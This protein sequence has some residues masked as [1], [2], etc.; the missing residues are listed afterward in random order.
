MKT[1]DI[2]P[3]TV[4]AELERLEGR[5]SPFSALYAHWERNQWSALELDLAPDRASFVALEPSEQSGLIWI[6]AHRFHAE[7][8]VARLLAPFLLAAPDYEVQLLLATQVADEHRHLQ[9]VLRIYEEVFGIQGGFEA[10][11]AVA[12]E[13]MDLVAGTLYDRLEHYVGRL[14]ADSGEEEFL[15]AVVVYHLLAEGVVARTAQNLAANR[16]EQLTFPGLAEGQRLVARDEARH[17]GIGVSYARRCMDERPE[18]ARAVIEDVVEDFV[19]IAERLLATA[20]EGMS[21]LV[22]TGYG[23]EPEGFYNEVMRLTQLRLRSIGFLGQ[24]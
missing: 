3:G 5:P 18:W 16:Y 8:N 7:F 13:N 24:D 23:V 14:S 19:A 6:F 9:A 4:A 10:V 21:D 17:I 12:D 1:Q 20:N 15:A 22:H 2:S 11:R